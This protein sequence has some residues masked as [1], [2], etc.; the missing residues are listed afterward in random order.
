MNHELFYSKQVYSILQ[1]IQQHA[2]QDNLIYE[3]GYINELNDICP[4]CQKEM[5]LS[6]ENEPDHGVIQVL[7]TNEYAVPYALC[8]FCT[9]IAER[10]ANIIMMNQLLFEAPYPLEEYIF[11]C[12]GIEVE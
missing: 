5:A 4:S 7:Y 9:E 2:D 10:P 11:R 3:P 6:V 8:P 1:Q 12:L